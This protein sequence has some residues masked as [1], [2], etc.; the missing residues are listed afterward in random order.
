MG[1]IKVIFQ[2]ISWNLS[3][4]IIFKVHL[5]EWA[6][7]NRTYLKQMPRPN[8]EKLE[9]EMIHVF[10][11]VQVR[12]SF[13]IHDVDNL[14]ERKR[15]MNPKLKYSLKIKVSLSRNGHLVSRQQTLYHYWMSPT[16]IYLLKVSHRNTRKR[17]AT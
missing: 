8:K 9:W 15:K 13:N 4:K 14:N 12:C 17:Y 10:H 3:Y 6:L 1:S 7:R 5:G 16:N 11:F 2:G